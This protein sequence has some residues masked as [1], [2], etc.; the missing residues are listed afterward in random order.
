MCKEDVQRTPDNLKLLSPQRGG[1]T[2]RLTPETPGINEKYQCLRVSSQGAT[3]F[4]TDAMPAGLGSFPIMRDEKDSGTTDQTFLFSS[5]PLKWDSERITNSKMES[6]L[7]VLPDDFPCDQKVLVVRGP[8]TSEALLLEITAAIRA[9]VAD[10]NVVFELSNMLNFP[11]SSFGAAVVLIPI[12][13]EI[14][15]SILTVLKPNGSAVFLL[16]EGEAE[17]VVLELKLADVPKIKGKTGSD[18]NDS[19]W[20]VFLPLRGVHRIGFFGFRISRIGAEISERKRAKLLSLRAEKLLFLQH[21]PKVD[22]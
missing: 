8:A 9:H 3:L 10:T 5:L 2:I 13:T 4:A 18:A 16:F 15:K 7:K 14:M 19:S 6:K 22:F 12:S 20:E 11:D 1:H 17:N 21:N